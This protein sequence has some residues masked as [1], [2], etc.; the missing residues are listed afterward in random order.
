MFKNSVQSLSPR[1]NERLYVERTKSIAYRISVSR[2][3][4]FDAISSLSRSSGIHSYF[5]WKD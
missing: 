3:K 2:K 4:H 5:S 1:Q